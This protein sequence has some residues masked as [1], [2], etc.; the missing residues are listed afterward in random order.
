MS[1]NSN[2][3]QK[4]VKRNDAR[5]LFSREHEKSSENLKK[6]WIK[7]RFFFTR[8]VGTFKLCGSRERSEFENVFKFDSNLNQI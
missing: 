1:A 3:L 8:K 6:S 7:I 5:K 4:I 2:F